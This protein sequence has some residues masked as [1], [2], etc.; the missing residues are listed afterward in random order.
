MKFYLKM[1]G[2]NTE[3]VADTSIQKP[4]SEVLNAERKQEAKLS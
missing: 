4:I 2:N 3:Q 1:E